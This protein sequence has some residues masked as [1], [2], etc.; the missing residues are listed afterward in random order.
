MT[1]T[2][3]FTEVT[4]LPPDS[5]YHKLKGLKNYR[6]ALIRLP[7]SL[8][9]S[10]IKSFNIDPVSNRISSANFI[11]DEELCLEM[12][13]TDS[14]YSIFLPVSNEQNDKRE[15]GLAFQLLEKPIPVWNVARVSS[16]CTK[17][18]L[19]DLTAEDLSGIPTLP[20]IPQPDVVQQKLVDCQQNESTSSELTESQPQKKKRKTKSKNSS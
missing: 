12:N 7:T 14:N 13:P 1:T 15:E 20:I 6:L 10:C 9:I 5:D 3:D 8:D 19:T 11:D 18:H 16:V 17:T 2:D 4:E